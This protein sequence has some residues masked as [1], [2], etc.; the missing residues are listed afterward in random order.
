MGFIFVFMVLFIP[1][2]LSRVITDLRQRFSGKKDSDGGNAAAA[3][4]VAS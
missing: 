2:G 1:G 4:E 3:K